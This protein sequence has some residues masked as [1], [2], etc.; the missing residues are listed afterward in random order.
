[1]F[2]YLDKYIFIYYLLKCL[3]ILFNI[4]LNIQIEVNLF[5]DQFYQHLKLFEIIFSRNNLNRMNV[6]PIIFYYWLLFKKEKQDIDI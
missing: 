6:F 3:F 1:M 4:L 2:I 5:I